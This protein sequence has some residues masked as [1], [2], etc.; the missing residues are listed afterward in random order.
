MSVKSDIL[1]RLYI[2]FG[3]LC[4]VAF[5]I[6]A[7]A[8]RIQFFEGDK[9]LEEARVSSRIDTTQGE[10]G[11]LYSSNNKLL[12]TSLPFF[13]IR[14]D[15]KVVSDSLFKASIDSLAFHLASEFKDRSQEEY[16]TLIADGRKNGKR[17]LL[18]KKNVN[19]NEKKR[20][21]KWP[22]FRLG[23][24]K[25]GFIPKQYDSRV[26]PFRKLA[27]RTIGYVRA[28]SKPVGIEGT[29]NQYL[30]GASIA[31]SMYRINGEWVPM[32]D[33]VDLDIRNGK[34]VYT[35]IDIDMQDKVESYLH[36][37]VLAHRAKW[38]TAVVM[39]VATGK[40]KA[41]ANLGLKAKREGP[42]T[43]RFNY[44]IG[45]KGDPG[46]T[47]K[48]VS[49]L[50]LLEDNKVN[51]NTIVNLGEGKIS[52]Y[53]HEIKDSWY[54][55]GSVTLRKMIEISS[56]VGISKLVTN[57]YKNDPQ[58]FIDRLTSM[59]VTE[60]TGVDIVGE[61][62]PKV[63]SPDDK[64]W[65]GITLPWMSM[66]H[67]VELTPLQMLTFVNAIAND[68]KMMR[69][70]VVTKV[71]KDNRV[72]EKF[73]PQVIKNKICSKENAQLVRSIME[74]V[75]RQGTAKSIYLAEY[76]MGA[77]TGTAEIAMG[78]RGYQE[79]YQASIVGFFPVEKPAYSCIVVINEPLGD[80]YYGGTVAG[81][82]FQKIVTNCLAAKTIQEDPIN[83][84]NTKY[85]V[86]NISIEGKG[87]QD[88]FATIYNSLGIPSVGSSNDW[89]TPIRGND[90]MLF[91]GLN[92]AE[93][94]KLIPNV[95]GMGL[96]DAIYKLENA[97]LKVRF[98]GR[99]KVQKQ[100]PISGKRYNRGDV[101]AL[102]LGV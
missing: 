95:V 80:D 40:I 2:V 64:D 39:E 102:E 72:L 57:A 69:P 26:N 77:K 75:V 86:K 68:G 11:N 34:D 96:R 6:L 59:N 93:K 54:Y 35:S 48:V 62:K 78:K 79:D 97:G 9:L 50:A 56:N 5:L 58:R 42:Y 94:S 53:D 88:D 12:A 38:G 36:E 3:T 16:R 30:K 91:R 21:E 24:Y 98:T 28:S 63:K 55:P 33:D 82:V 14:F 67:E 23:R 13:E 7:Q 70:Y 99:G 100:A 101:V 87:Y 8:F 20:A 44:A 49:L 18:I 51:E 25:G 61:V 45:Q 85:L 83:H 73:E 71:A 15:T 4:L 47:F 41:I 17:Y 19:Y 89:I 46:S 1:L 81:P 90:T 22:I 37:T 31:Q 66:G 60:P 76:P 32:D 92:A 29:Y 65:S 10:R 52:F 74:G 84:Y 43:E 27:Q